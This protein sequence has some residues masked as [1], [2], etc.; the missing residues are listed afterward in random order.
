[1]KIGEGWRE[2]ENRSIEAGLAALPYV[3]RKQIDGKWIRVLKPD[4]PPEAQKLLDEWIEANQACAQY[5]W[6]TEMT[7]S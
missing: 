3:E 1:M 2:L 5:R 4:A 6:E 7:W